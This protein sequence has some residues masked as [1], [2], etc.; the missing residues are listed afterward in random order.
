VHA[1]GREPSEEDQGDLVIL[2]RGLIHTVTASLGGLTLLSYHSPFLELD[3]PRQYAIPETTGGA[4]WV[5][6]VGP[7]VKGHFT[8]NGVSSPRAL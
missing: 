2:T 7:T 4:D 8:H 6:S 5:W 1:S 3:N